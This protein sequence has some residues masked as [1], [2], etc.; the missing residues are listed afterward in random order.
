MLPGKN[1]T[2]PEPIIDFDPA[3]TSSKPLDCLVIGAGPAGLTAA[4]YLARFHL[5]VLVI[6][7]GRGRAASIPMSHNVSGFPEGISGPTLLARMQE[8]AQ[9]YG[10]AVRKGEVSS[11][12][13]DDDVLIANGTNF[14]V[15]ARTVLLATGVV[16][17]RPTI[18]DDLHDEALAQGLLRYCPICDGYEMTDR[19]I[20]V[21]GTGA[22]G[23]R[24]AEF[25]RSYSDDVTLIAP[26]EVH[27]P[28]VAKMVPLGDSGIKMVNGP[29]LRFLLMQDEIIVEL[30]SGRLA[31][32]AIYPALGTDVC[33]Q[34]ARC[35]GA[36]LSADGCI[37]VD[38][39]QRTDV[40]GLYAAGDV[41]VGLD[42]ISNA[43]G[44][45]GVAAAAIR[46]DLAVRRALRR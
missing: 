20:G 36:H 28:D 19:R 18:P 46:N 40:P 29:C 35:A 41:V 8:Q 26:D 9:R 24:E 6:D 39:H 16:N 23:L 1:L 14:V 25:L 30:P 44:Q 21:I 33:S 17:R 12:R 22:R 45:A 15:P 10:A 3:E 27:D 13:M 2:L 7:A 34:L 11:L 4:I 42:Q 32:G 37:A 5:S 31:F 43:I 38:R